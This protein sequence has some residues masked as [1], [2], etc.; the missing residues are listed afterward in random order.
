MSRSLII[1][2][3]VAIFCS[4]AYA[5]PPPRNNKAEVGKA[6]KADEAT[7]IALFKAN[8]ADSGIVGDIKNVNTL[9]KQA[10]PTGTRYVADVQFT[11]RNAFITI[12]NYGEGAVESKIN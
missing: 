12:E 11:D 5:P 4:V 1:F 7:F 2:A 9:T 8:Q 10:L 3:L 6:S